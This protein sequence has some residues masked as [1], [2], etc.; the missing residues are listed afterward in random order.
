MMMM[1]VIVVVVA[2]VVGR[3]Y[4]GGADAGPRSPRRSA[5]AADE[6]RGNGGER[7][8][9]CVEKSYRNPF[10]PSCQDREERRRSS[11]LLRNFE[12]E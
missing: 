11:R 10:A 7:T 1:M 3:S 4:G 6:M 8:A 9:P 12:G 2:M 5:G